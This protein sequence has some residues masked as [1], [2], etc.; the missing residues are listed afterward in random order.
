MVEAGPA[1]GHASCVAAVGESGKVDELALQR[2]AGLCGAGDF[3]ADL[4]AGVRRGV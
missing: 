2:V 1:V 4:D 3:G